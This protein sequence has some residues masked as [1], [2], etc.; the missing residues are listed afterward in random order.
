[1]N[2]Q[3]L[4]EIEARAAAATPGPWEPQEGTK[5]LAMGDMGEEKEYFVIRDGDDISIC[6]DC[7]TPDG[8]ASPEN[9]N[10]IAHARQDVPALCA[11]MR[12]LNGELAM[13]MDAVDEL[14]RQMAE[15]EQLT[16]EN[17]KLRAALRMIE[18]AV[19]PVQTELGMVA[20]E[21]VQELIDIAA[22][23]INGGAS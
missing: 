2:E 14:S 13:A 9:A 18:A 6:C 23:A 15:I 16:A 3:E 21:D 10:F 22:E 19:L 11:E 12:R 4:K 17:A 1:M 8:E 7:S 5:Y 20:V